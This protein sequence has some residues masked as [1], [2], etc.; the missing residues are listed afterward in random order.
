MTKTVLIIWEH[1][2][3]LGHLSR[4]LPIAIALRDAQWKVIFAVADKVSAQRFLAPAGFNCIKLPRIAPKVAA[5]ISG[6]LNHAEILLRMGFERVDQVRSVLD[7]WYALFDDIKPT[8]V[9]VDASPVALYAARSA[10]IPTVVIGHGF[11]IPPEQAPRPC[12]MPWVENSVARAEELELRLER[13]LEELAKT[14]PARLRKNAP[15]SMND[16]FSS[17]SIALCAWSELDHFDRPAGVRDAS[18]VYF[19]PIWSE[20]PGGELLSWPDGDGP[21][22]LCYLNLRDKR[23]DL[24]WQALKLQ[25]ANVLVIS[26]SGLPRA[27]EAARGWGIRVVEHPVQLDP[28]IRDSAA[29]VGNGG[30]GL[31]SMSLQAG[32]RI[33]LLPEHMEQAILAYRLSK[34]GL[35]LATIR[36]KI[37][38]VVAE[39]VDQLL[40]GEISAERIKNFSLRHG[41]YRPG[42]AVQKTVATLSKLGPR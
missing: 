31:T 11:E 13:A 3:N 30:M 38:T 5:A 41:D 7:R 9:L 25:G 8:A 23:Y 27:C 17:D 20:S 6:P 22:V 12:F 28:L 1:G 14:I 36:N 4:L 21:K 2:G 29:I 34:Q 39:K 42:V 15:K 32:K 40:S 26:P 18:D 35:A 10:G 24:T 19:G 33:L 37:K 16:L